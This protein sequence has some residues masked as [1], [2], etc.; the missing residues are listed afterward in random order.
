MA[1][2]LVYARL[3][4]A[5]IR[6]Q[7][8]YRLAALG[9]LVANV[10]FGF[11]KVAILLATVQAAGGVLRGYDTQMMSTYIW[12][13]QGLLGSVNLFGRTDLGTRIKSGQVAVNFLRPVDVHLAELL[14]EFGRSVWALLPRGLPSVLIGAVT[15]GLA[16]TPWLPGLPLGVISLFLGIAISAATVY[17][18]G[19]S[20][21]WL[22]ETRGVQIFYMVV[23]GFLAGLFV[24]IYL[25]PPWLTV[26]AQATPFPSMMMYPIDILSGRAV[27]PD[28]VVLLLQQLAWLLLMV[29]LGQWLTRAGRHHLEVQGG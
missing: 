28:A 12:I 25:F 4:L 16:F 20:G 7:S 15:V 14:Q 26:L 3:V 6:E 10:T 2:G 11:L 9:G 19:A 23:S 1:A 13:G 8:A 17:P 27:G 22:V 29:G 5:G 24:P 21:F 18:V